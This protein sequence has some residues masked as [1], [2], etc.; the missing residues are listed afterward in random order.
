MVTGTVRA[1]WSG[2]REKVGDLKSDRVVA[3]IEEQIFSGQLSAGTRLPPENE[4]CEALGV[5]RT[6][7]RDAV[8][9]LVAR[10]LLNVR[11]GRGT[12]VAEPNEKAYAESIVALLARSSLRVSDVME[13]RTSI[14]TMIARIACQA[15]TSE[16]WEMLDQLDEA[17][18][19]AIS[20]GDEM[21]AHTA[22]A[23][24]HSGI[25]QATHQ[26]ALILMLNSLNQVAQLTGTASI[27]AG[28]MSDW[29]LDAHRS[30]LVALKSGDPD[31]AAQAMETH[32]TKLNCMPSYEAL[33]ERP[34]SEVYLASIARK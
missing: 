31:R 29:D 30:I 4:L 34:F 21:A 1:G 27:R 18:M 23:A 22:H 9:I 13:A 20:S 6:V 15:G 24:F 8:R 25:L 17:L 14:E 2:L 12:V 28:N 16:D 32:F 3:V 19:G 10:G 33:R 7:L 26:P 11:Q 5:S